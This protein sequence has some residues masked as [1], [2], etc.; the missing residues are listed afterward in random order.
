LALRLRKEGFV[1]V[2]WREREAGGKVALFLGAEDA[3]REARE[4]VAG[5]G[6]EAGDSWDVYDVGADVEGEGEGQGFHCCKEMLELVS[7]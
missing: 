6:Y 5:S 2:G 1:G 3:A 4:V 7:S